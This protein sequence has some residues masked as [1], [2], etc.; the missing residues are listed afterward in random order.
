MNLGIAGAEFRQSQGSFRFQCSLL[1]VSLVAQSSRQLIVRIAGLGVF[2]N[3]LSF[4]FDSL[5]EPA[6]Q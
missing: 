1:K 4:F 2:F 5:F 3:G 6:H